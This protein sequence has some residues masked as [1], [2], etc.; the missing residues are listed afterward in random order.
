MARLLSTQRHLT[1]A[2]LVLCVCAL[3]GCTRDQDRPST[4]VSVDAK[5]RHVRLQLDWYPQAEHGGFFQAL[6]RGFYR[7]AGLDVEILSGGPGPR[8]GARLIGGAADLAIHR[9]DDVLMHAAEGLP[10]V[11][12]GVFMQHDPQALL[13]HAESPVHDFADLDGRTVVA[14]PGS[15]WLRYL[16]R[17]HG[18]SIGLIPHTWSL[19]QFMGDRDLVQQCF[20]TNEP[21]VV[22]QQGVDI[23]TLLIAGSGYD[24]YR[25][26][27]TTRRFADAEPGVVAAFV[28]ASTRGWEDYI[29]GDPQPAH[30]LILERNDQFTPEFLAY[31]DRAMREHRLIAGDPSR[32]ESI[33]TMNLDRLRKEAE[34][35]SELGL[36]D[37]PPPL[38]RYVR[39][40]TA[41]SANR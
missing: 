40:P 32:G 39:A 34:L 28:A 21:Y 18:I 27:F 33:G 7:E 12:V 30:A 13:V 19:T 31:S 4:R 16:E 36:L 10:F 35:L 26:I 14:V 11:I 24:P 22:R 2:L 23:R 37:E 6:A 29:S 3:V 15:N 25:V 20:I 8:T 38:E 9:S 41:D 5:L 17:R 1:R